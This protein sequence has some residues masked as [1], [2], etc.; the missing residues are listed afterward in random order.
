MRRS[1]VQD[2]EFSKEQSFRKQLSD[3]RAFQQKLRD[4]GVEI[5]RK[6]FSIPLTEKLGVGYYYNR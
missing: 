2:D 1:E 4:V 6:S 5:E 3:F